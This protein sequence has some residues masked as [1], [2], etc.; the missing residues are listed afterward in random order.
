MRPFGKPN[1]GALDFQGRFFYDYSII[2]SS[3]M[4]SILCHLGQPRTAKPQSLQEYGRLR[5]KMIQQPWACLSEKEFVTAVTQKG[6]PFYQALMQG[7][8]LMELQFERLVWRTQSLVGLDFD[9]C[10]VGGWEMLLTFA[11]MGLQPMLGYHTFSH[12]P[13]NGGESYRLIWRVETDLNLTYDECAKALKKMRVLSGNLSD[14]NAA[15]PTRMWQ[16]TTRGAFCYNS[17][18]TRLNLKEL[19]SD[20]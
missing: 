3:A 1:L 2:K 15:N 9:V 20:A 18:S 14:K 19:A 12:D 6:Q 13:D 11:N 16:G 4:S 7:G 10:E 8:D 5:E 17:E